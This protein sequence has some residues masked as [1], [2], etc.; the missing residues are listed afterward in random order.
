MTGDIDFD[1]NKATDVTLENFQEVMAS[2]TNVSGSVT[3]PDA[4]NNVSYTLTGNTTSLPCRI[5]T[6]CRQAPHAQS[7]HLREARQHWRSHL[8]TCCSRRLLHQVQQLVYAARCKIH[9]RTKRPSI[10]LCSWKGSTTIYVSLF[11]GGLNVTIRYDEIHLYA[12][13]GQAASATVRQ[14]LDTEGIAYTNLDYPDPTETLAA[15][16]TWF[17]G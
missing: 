4:T 6:S 5:L 11:S 7:N 1:N 3:V 2:N 15:L 13:P 9:Q 16:S 8:H 12:K 14:W 10:Q 17:S